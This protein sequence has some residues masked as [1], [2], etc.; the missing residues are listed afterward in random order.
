MRRIA[1]AGAAL[2]LSWLAGPSCSCTHQNIPRAYPAPTVEQ[3]LTHVRESGEAAR[4]YKTESTMDYW[5][6][7]QRI[8]ATVLV[9]GERGSKA[10]FKALNPATDTAAADLVCDGQRFVF[11]NYDKSCQLSGTCD[12]RAIGQLLRVSMEPDDFLLLA[13]GSVPI[14]PQPSGRVRWDERR[15]AE[16]VELVSQD[17]AWRQTLVLDGRGG[18]GKWDVLESVVTDAQGAVDWKVQNK[19]F[20]AL[21]AADGRTIRVPSATRFEQPRQKADLQVRWEERTVNAELDDKAFQRE[22]PQLGQCGAGQGAAS[23]R[24]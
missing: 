11:V 14:I 24:R 6:G 4:S 18:A 12:R 5:V 2:A 17:R 7:D 19:D 15:G 8:K 9:M 21:K 16:V 10:F 23:S 3:L 13:V 1:L 20:R 22:V